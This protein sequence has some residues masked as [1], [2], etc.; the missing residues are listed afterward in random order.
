MLKKILNTQNMTNPTIVFP[1]KI[2][3]VCNFS[4]SG[5]KMMV[6]IFFE[7]PPCVHHVIFITEIV[8][9]TKTPQFYEVNSFNR[10]W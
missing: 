9:L 1:V 2:E 4:I 6:K 8:L 3:Y 10:K 7:I 5:L